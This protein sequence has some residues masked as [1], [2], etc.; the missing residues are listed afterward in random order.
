MKERNKRIA[1]GVLGIFFS[2]YLVRSD[3]VYL[4]RQGYA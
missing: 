1:Y 4:T 3:Y 2:V